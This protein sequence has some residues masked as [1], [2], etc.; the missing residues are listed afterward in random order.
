[1]I[2]GQSFH[3]YYSGPNALCIYTNLHMYFFSLYLGWLCLIFQAFFVYSEQFVFHVSVAQL[4]YLPEIVW[5]TW[6][7]IMMQDATGCSSVKTMNAASSSSEIMRVHTP[8][9]I[10]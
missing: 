10:R 7:T 4:A 9:I 6:M 1:M 3:V 2:T 8:S 5:R